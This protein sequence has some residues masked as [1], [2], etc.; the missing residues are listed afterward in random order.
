MA[1]W[2][3]HVLLTSN[4]LEKDIILFDM[5]GRLL[6]YSFIANGIWS[7]VLFRCTLAPTSGIGH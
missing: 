1:L 6:F 4:S 2:D 5:M 7:L 3:P